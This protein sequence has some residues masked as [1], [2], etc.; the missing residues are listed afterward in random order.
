MFYKRPLRINAP[1]FKGNG[2]EDGFIHCFKEDEP[3]QNCREQ[4]ISQ[5]DVLDEPDRP[6]P[7][8]MITDSNV[9]E[10]DNAIFQIEED[11]ENH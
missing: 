2:S 4:L 7:F 9:D 8:D 1:L 6:N 10:A 11:D 3:C 5:L